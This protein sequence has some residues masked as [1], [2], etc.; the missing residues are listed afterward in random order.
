MLAWRAASLLLVALVQ[1]A[2][3]RAPDWWEHDSAWHTELV[4]PTKR[5]DSSAA[6]DP[7]SGGLAF[8]EGYALYI[9]TS[10]VGL[11]F[12]SADDLLETL[13]K[14]PR[15]SKDDHSIG[16]SWILLE[17]PD[18]R[19]ECG[20]T[21]E[22]GVTSPTY[23]EAF[24]ERVR[25]HDPNPVAAIWESKPDG[26][27]HDGSDSHRPTFVARIPITRDQH[28]RLIDY[29]THYDYS[30]FSLVDRQCTDFA[31]GAARV[32]GIELGHRIRIELPPRVFFRGRV[33]QIWQDDKYRILEI[34]TPDLLEDDLKTLVKQG[35]ATD[36]TR[37]YLDD[38]AG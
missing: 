37:W 29:V 36:A 38:S 9:A 25:Q 32:V 14:H 18:G 3:Y 28:A 16:H 10:A 34:G 2:C 31:A 33:I 19:L 27:F 26:K 6:I 1:L 13:H 30:R 23:Y 4:Q 24:L 5:I 35:Y 7:R 11:S 12:A 21:G 15:T 20:L 8:D 17:S 22:Y